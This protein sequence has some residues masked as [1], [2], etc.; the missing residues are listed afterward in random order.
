M[1]NKRVVGVMTFLLSLCFLVSVSAETILLKSGKIVE[2]EI[3]ERD[4]ER[5]KV[6]FL[7]VSL[8]YYLDEIESIDREKITLPLIKEEISLPVEDKEASQGGEHYTNQEYGVKLWYPK[9]WEVFDK[10]IHPEVFKS[11]LALQP[12]NVPAELI[13]ALSCG[14][15]WNN[16]EPIIMVIVQ[17]VTD[18]FK[19]LLAEDLAKVMEQNLQQSFLPPGQ[20]IVEYSKV[21]T[22]G[23]KKLVKHIIV[24]DADS[25]RTKNVGYCFIKGT[26]LYMINCVTGLENFDVYKTVIE[27]IAGSVR[28]D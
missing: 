14:K 1:N 18:D 28:L 12:P 11:L 22:A 17:Q 19:D 21:F 8:T 15:D 5:I 6:D 25:P 10:N 13:C 27:N 24:G 2:G 9:D 4:Q 23:G 20:R 3:I 26:K 7:G 16:L